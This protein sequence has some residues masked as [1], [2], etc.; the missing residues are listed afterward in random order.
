MND[1]KNISQRLEIAIRNDL[2]CN[3]P[4]AQQMANIF[5]LRRSGSGGGIDVTT[6]M[7]AEK[8]IISIK[9]SEMSKKTSAQTVHDAIKEKVKRETWTKLM[10]ELDEKQLKN[11]IRAGLDSGDIVIQGDIF[12]IEEQISKEIMLSNRFSNQAI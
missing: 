3:G 11:V 2:A 12:G 8:K 7:N 4:M 5:G 1:L 9:D 10:I 6:L